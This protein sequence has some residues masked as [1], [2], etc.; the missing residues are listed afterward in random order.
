MVS[1]VFLGKA[2]TAVTTV[3]QDVSFEDGFYLVLSLLFYI[4]TPC[5]F[6]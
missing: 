2:L 1:S 6:W 3:L 5:M 4:K